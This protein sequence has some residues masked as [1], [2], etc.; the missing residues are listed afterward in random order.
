[1]AYL[2]PV[3]TGFTNRAN[4]V[5]LNENVVRVGVNY[6]FDLPGILFSTVFG[7]H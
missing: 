7:R 1:M 2:N 4:G 5:S 6:H 3:P